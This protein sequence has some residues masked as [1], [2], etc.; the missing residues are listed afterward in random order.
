MKVAKTESK[1]QLTN[2]QIQMCIDGLQWEI[3]L[4][5]HWTSQYKMLY[6]FITVYLGNFFVSGKT[7]FHHWIHLLENVSQISVFIEN[8][9]PIMYRIHSLALKVS[10]VISVKWVQ[11]LSIADLFH[12]N[13]KWILHH[14]SELALPSTPHWICS[15]YQICTFK[16]R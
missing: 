15:W 3:L 8:Q 7:V 1:I 16:N 5:H 12:L 4:R 10:L 13:L 2:M 14:I 11:K 6:F 9:H